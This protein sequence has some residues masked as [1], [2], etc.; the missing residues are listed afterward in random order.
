[1]KW[2]NY[3]SSI[4]RVKLDISGGMSMNSINSKVIDKIEKTEP[5]KVFNYFYFSDITDNYIALSK[6]LSRLTKN[7]TIKSVEKGVFYKP[8]KTKYGEIN[9][10]AEEIIRNEIKP[11]DQTIGYIT[12]INMFNRLGFTT[13]ISN[14][15]EIAI[16]KR[17]KPKVIMGIKI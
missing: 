7:K 13:Q 12:G 6:S 11:G 16:R 8:Q 14:V 2:Y 5:G 9:P 17:R 1:M 10:N 15:V 4:L 3:P